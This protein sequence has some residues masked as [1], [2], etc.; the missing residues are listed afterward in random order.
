MSE[1]IYSMPVRL[2]LRPVALFNINGVLNRTV[3]IERFH[4]TASV[5][6]GRPRRRFILWSGERAPPSPP[7][8]P[9]SAPVSEDCTS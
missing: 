1:I 5:N 2:M 9:R 7:A 4:I 8:A 6:G 3:K